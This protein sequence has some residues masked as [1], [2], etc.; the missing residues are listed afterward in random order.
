MTQ[1]LEVAPGVEHALDPCCMVIFGASGD[2]THRMLLPALYDL[3]LDRRLPPRFAIVGFARTKWSDDDFRAEAKKSVSEFARRPLDPAIWDNFAS[4][5]HYIAGAYD[6]QNSYIRLNETLE[7][8]GREGKS[9]GNHIFYLAVPPNTFPLVVEQLERGP[10]S[11]SQGVAGW[12]RVIIEKPFGVNLQS[13]RELNRSLHAAFREDD[14]YRIDHYLGK[15]TVQNILVFRFANGILEPVWNRRYVDHIQITVAESLGVERRGS[16][17]DGTGA[18]RD[19]VQNHMMQLVSLIAM[20]P[21]VAYDGR[22]VRNEKVKVLQAVRRT[23]PREVGA[24]TASG[25][26]GRGWVAGEEVPGYHDEQEVDPNSLT[27]TFVAVKAYIDSWRWGDVPFYLR[28]G[29]RLPKRATEIAVTFKRVPHTLFRESV[30]E[31]HLEPNVLSL[32]IQPNEGISL[33][34]LTKVP[35]SRLRVRPANMDFLYGASF[36]LQAPSAY[37]TLILDAMRGDATLFTRSD[38]VEAAWEIIDPIMEGWRNMRSPSFPNYEAGTWGPEEADEL[39]ER[40]GRQW[41]RL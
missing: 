2:L 24:M 32:R 14:V 7:R 17:Y 18:L 36:L 33:K 25:Q 28:T 35:G 8:L 10:H 1:T 4:N 41:R 27:E 26:Y 30:D 39:I 19:M 34:F 13:A 22:S 6:D 21:P 3:A 40:D 15:E 11:R 31:P 37:E 16:Y 38:E 29:K 9:E 23:D 5:L 12:S 20:E